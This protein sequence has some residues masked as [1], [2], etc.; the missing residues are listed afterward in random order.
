MALPLDWMNDWKNVD[1]R[2]QRCL[3]IYPKDQQSN[4]WVPRDFSIKTDCPDYFKS[5]GLND[6]KY[7]QKCI[8]EEKLCDM[9]MLP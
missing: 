6:R 3:G 8:A 1:Y 9:V 4:I 2:D 5:I 7:M